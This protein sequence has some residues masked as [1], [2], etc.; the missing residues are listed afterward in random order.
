LRLSW[1]GARRSNSTQGIS[2]ADDGWT[3]MWM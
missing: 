1:F 3:V 2:I